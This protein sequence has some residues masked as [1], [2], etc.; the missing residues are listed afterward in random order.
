MHHTCGWRVDVITNHSENRFFVLRAGSL[1]SRQDISDRGRTVIEH[2][3]RKRW[4]HTNPKGLIH[5]D[6][7]VFQ[8]TANAEFPSTHIGLTRQVAGE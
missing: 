7:R 3:F 1:A 6:V 5:D 4:L 2:G 8:F